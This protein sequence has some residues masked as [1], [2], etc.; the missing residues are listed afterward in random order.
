[1]GVCVFVASG[2]IFDVDGYLP[3][4][5]FKAMRAFRKGHI[6]PK[7]NPQHQPRPDS[8]FVVLVAQS[9]ELGLSRELPEAM[10]FLLKHEREIL[11]LKDLGVDNMLLDF[12]IEHQGKI[13]EAEYL[14]ASE[15]CLIARPSSEQAERK[16][17]ISLI[18]V[19]IVVKWLI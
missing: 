3:K 11:R 14:L 12:G 6:P 8:G 17:S 4:S 1:M 5:P 2:L 9:P 13:Q 15:F 7:D 16:A 10:K 18:C 19:F